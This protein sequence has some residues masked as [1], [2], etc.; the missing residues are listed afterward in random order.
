MNAAQHEPRADAA[1]LYSV[2]QVGAILGLRKSAVYE[3]MAA[4]ELP[5]VL[6]TARHRMVKATDLEDFIDARRTGGWNRR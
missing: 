6:V 3:L 2:D 5:F 1:L 4:G